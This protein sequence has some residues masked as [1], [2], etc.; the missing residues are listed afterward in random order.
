MDKKDNLLE[1]LR[2]IFSW[3]KQIITVC[4]IAALGAI[5]ISLLLSNYYRSGT[6]FYAASQDLALPQPV[7]NPLKEREYYGQEEDLER[8]LAIAGSRE[9][10]D[11]IISRFKLYEH[12]GIDST[13]KKAAHRVRLRF[14]KYYEVIKTK[15]NGIELTFED[16]DPQFAAAVANAAR[17]RISEIAQR[18]FKET[19]Y[20]K[21]ESL[22]VNIQAKEKDL[23]Q[24][25]DSLIWLTNFYGI[26]D[27]LSQSEI[28]A[29]LEARAKSK[30]AR[31]RAKLSD[32]QTGSTRL[33]DS[34]MFLRAEVKGMEAELDTLQ[35]AIKLYNAGVPLVES[36]VE[37]LKE[38]R[39]QLAMD[40]ERYKQLNAVFLSDIPTIIKLEDAGIP[41]VKSR[42]R[43]S[44]I[45]IGTVVI[46]FLFSV[47]AVL[48]IDAYREVAWKEIIRGQ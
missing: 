47:L 2:T 42:P 45:V 16:K 43:R 9:L 25:G 34:I 12:Y 31:Y 44:I 26:Y 5:I 22:K 18:L 17:D 32:L 10:A 36:I 20:K 11:Y 8:I 4:F 41:V 23:V 27:P 37:V 21:L 24:L 28:L 15:Y 33:R 14:N 7:G 40:K 6:T 30:L 46:A 29:G 19:Q 13:A 35:K 48:V 3:Q 1:V 38:A 39:D